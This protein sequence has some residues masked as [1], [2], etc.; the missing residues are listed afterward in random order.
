MN[1]RNRIVLCVFALLLLAG[2]AKT[3]VIDHEKLYSG[4]LPRPAH[5]WVYDFAA[6]PADLP[7]DSELVR[8]YSVSGPPQTPEDIATGRKLGALIATELVKQIRDMGMPGERGGCREAGHDRPGL[9]VVGNERSGRNLPGDGS[10][11]AQARVRRG[12]F[13][14]KQNPRVSRRCGRLNCD[15]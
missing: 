5:I 11:I 10:G 8:L 12:R 2:C 14:R 3:K 4:Q 6:T 15:R 9:G 1:S 7:A 13:R